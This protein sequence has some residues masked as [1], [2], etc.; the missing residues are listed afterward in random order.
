M[1]SKKRSKGS[2]TTPR[3]TRAKSD[4]AVSVQVDSEPPDISASRGIPGPVIVDI[5]ASSGGLDAIKK[6]LAAM[7]R[8]SGIAFVLIPDLDPTHENLTPELIAQHTSIPV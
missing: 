1:A 3:P 6:L 8:D 7:P 5:G 4:A 2:K